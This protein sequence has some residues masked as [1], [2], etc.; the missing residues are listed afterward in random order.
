[1][2]IEHILVATDFSEAGNYA[3]AEAT[4]WARRYRSA[5]HVV[6]I[7]PPK[8]WFSGIFGSS[9]ILHKIACDRAAELLKHVSDGIDTTHIPHISTG[10]MEGPAARTITRAAQE[11]GADLLMIGARGEHREVVDGIGLGGTAAKLV[12]MPTIPT[13][14]VRRESSP[15]APIV[16]AP[17]DL[18][19]LSSSVLQWA[20]RCSH[21]GELRILHVHEVPFAARLRTYGV[22]ESAIDVY[23]AEE[24]TRRAAELAR[25]IEGANPPSTVR[26]QQSIQRV[27]SS[28]QL[29]QQI[30]DFTGGVLVLGKHLSDSERIGPNYSSV[31][32]YAARWC[33][34]NILIVP[35]D[36]TA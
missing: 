32:E 33:P 12:R 18:T 2:K 3:L 19:P 1:L 34:A 21:D 26:I 7:V 28:A 35:P 5:L 23:A 11:L 22:A 25:L 10:V 17:V 27:D 8:R 30:R 24:D 15:T 6:H 13:M 16:F 29:L 31:C 36:A 20:L 9:D 4:A 14:L